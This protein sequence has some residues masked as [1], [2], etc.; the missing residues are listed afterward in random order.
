[1]KARWCVGVFVALVLASP[2]SGQVAL[3]ARSLP[4]KSPG[5]LSYEMAQFSR[6][7]DGRGV[8]AASRHRLMTARGEVK[9]VVE[10]REGSTFDIAGH[11]G[12]LGGKVDARS[13]DWVKV[14]VPATRLEALAA[15]ADVVRVRAPFAPTKKNIVVSEGVELI[16]ADFF[17]FLTGANGNGVKVG[18]LDGN[19]AEAEAVLALGELPRDTTATQFVLDRLS[20][21]EDVHGTAAAEIVHDVA[22]GASIVLAGFDDEVT[23]A[24]AIDELYATG[25]RII[26]HSIGFDNLFPPDGQHYFAKKVDQ[27]ADA[28]VLFVTAAGNE[29][30]NYHQTAW[31]DRNNNAVLDFGTTEFLPVSASGAGRVVV[32]WNDTYNR[33]GHDYD[34]FL[35]NEA[36]RANPVL[37]ADN[38]NILDASADVQRGEGTPLEVLEYEVEAPQTLYV[39]IAHDRSTPLDSQ[40][41]FWIFS[42]G[43]IGEGFRN[44]A[45]TLTLPGDARG[46]LTVG[47]VDVYTTVLESYSSL[48]PTADGRVKPDLVAPDNVTTLAYELEPFRGTSAATPHVAGAAALLASFDRLAT[49]GDVRRA[50]ERSTIKD[51]LTRDAAGQPV[52]SNKFGWGLLDL[53]VLMT[54]AKEPSGTLSTLTSGR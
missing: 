24:Q 16:S 11:V 36:F 40:Q 47:A 19:F 45:G 22:P 3:D 39:V 8:N 52:K 17:A 35:V 50:L 5:K 37:S 30:E 26:S 34:A 29:A 42:S 51:A 49:M 54:G 9:A 20:R 46:A 7:P 48:G 18:V 14:R 1:M 41:K 2:A 33:S 6:I 53:F 15:P 31:S 44:S 13:G 38:P 10:L 21:Y 28:G 12:A 4:E 43:G 25:V 27:A 32:R 23:W